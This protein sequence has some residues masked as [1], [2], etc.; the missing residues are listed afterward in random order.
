[1]RM[2]RTSS[3]EEQKAASI[4]DFWTGM[5]I[6]NSF[7]PSTLNMSSSAFPSLLIT[8]H[9]MLQSTAHGLDSPVRGWMS[10]RRRRYL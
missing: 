4:Y 6:E 8:D 10:P 7:Q 1:M 2:A 3:R 9:Q 5:T